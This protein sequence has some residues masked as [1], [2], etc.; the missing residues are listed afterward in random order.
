MQQINEKSHYSTIISSLNKEYKQSKIGKTITPND[1]YLLDVV[2]NLLQ[3]CCLE[4]NNIEIKKLL[5]IYNTV[6]HTSKIV[7]N[8]NYQEVYQ[9]SKK[10]KFIQAEKT[11]CN[12][13]SN[14]QKVY[15]WQEPNIDILLD[16]IINN[17]SVN[18]YLQT[19]SFDTIPTFEIGKTISYTSIGL[20]SF[21]ITNSLETDNYRIYD[22]MN[23]DVTESFTRTYLDNKTILF[24]SNNIYS[25]GDLFI[26]LLKGEPLILNSPFVSTQLYSENGFP[27]TFEILQNI[28]NFVDMY[29]TIDNNNVI[30]E[31]IITIPIVF[32]VQTFE[33]TIPFNLFF[34]DGVAKF[35]IYYRFKRL[36]NNSF[37][38]I[39]FIEYVK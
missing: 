23:N 31:T 25:Y 2:Y 14:L 24:V 13:I 39:Y 37:S 11:D 6:L 29:I 33:E 18:G 21:A 22:I 17:V 36:D 9:V 1:I 3:G 35:P 7:C 8:N 26:K 32:G 4:L 28:G 12:T 16:D 15:Y 5:K 34:E 30:T 20:I 19:K 10:D 38:E 27:P